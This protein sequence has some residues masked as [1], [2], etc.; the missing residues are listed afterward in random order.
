M[1]Q[2]VKVSVITLKNNVFGL[3]FQAA[4]FIFCFTQ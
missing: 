3:L 2:A 1:A 4:F